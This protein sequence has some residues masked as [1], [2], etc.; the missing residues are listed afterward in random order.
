[1]ATVVLSPGQSAA[2]SS[3]ITVAD[4]PVV[5]M[6]YTD[7]DVQIP[8]GIL[9]DLQRKTNINTWVDVYTLEYDKIVFKHHLNLI[10]LT[11]AGTYRVTRPNITTYGTN[12]GVEIE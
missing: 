12:V 7:T 5:V 2:N 8:N 6:A 10:V 1:M 9:L 4:D 11:Y 3:D